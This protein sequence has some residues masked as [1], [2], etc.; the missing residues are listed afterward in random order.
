[1]KKC[2][3]RHQSLCLNDVLPFGYV[4]YNEQGV[5]DS[6]GVGSIPGD[7]GYTGVKKVVIPMARK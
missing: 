2:R 3:R 7:S 6:V 5:K 4:P 1:M